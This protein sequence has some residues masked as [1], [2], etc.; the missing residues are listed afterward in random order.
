MGS[1]PHGSSR[2][3][4]IVSRVVHEPQLITADPGAEMA[5]ELAFASY[6]ARSPAARV[7]LGVV[8]ASVRAA[9]IDRTPS[10]EA[11]LVAIVSDSGNGSE[12][13]LRRKPHRRCRADHIPQGDCHHV[14]T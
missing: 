7:N 4:T 3:R 6:L 9:E 8:D 5:S 2:H 14:I 13:P 12:D 10:Q 11:N 1:V